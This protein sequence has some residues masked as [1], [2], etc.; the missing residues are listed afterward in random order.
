MYGRLSPPDPVI[1]VRDMS[2]DVDAIEHAMDHDPT[3]IDLQ[4]SLNRLIA[5]G[6]ENA[7]LTTV[8]KLRMR[9]V[10]VAQTREERNAELRAIDAETEAAIAR[11]EARG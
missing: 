11:I 5:E 2:D 6:D 4:A 7:L 10:L 8:R 1:H 3:C 9:A